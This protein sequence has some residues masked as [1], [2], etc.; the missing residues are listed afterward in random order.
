[1]EIE[2]QKEKQTNE[3]RHKT[4]AADIKL[5]NKSR[6]FA[7]L[8][9]S[10]VQVRKVLRTRRWNGMASNMIDRCWKGKS[11]LT[12][13]VELCTINFCHHRSVGLPPFCVR[14]AEPDE[15]IEK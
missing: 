2:Q 4:H 5:S 10:A 7:L 3:N 15:R 13:L 8:K 1:M 6:N 14:G 11:R 12:S 9:A